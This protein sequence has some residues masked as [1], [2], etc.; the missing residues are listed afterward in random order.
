MNILI[1]G[2]GGFLGRHL[3]R[4]L[5]DRGKV[6]AFSRS[7]DPVTDGLANVNSVAGDVRNKE[8]VNACIESV[9]PDWIIHAA[10]QSYP[11]VSWDDPQGTFEVNV[12]GT[13]NVLEAARQHTPGARI[14][15][16]SSSA[17]YGPVANSTPIAET[18]PL[19]GQSPYGTSK[20]ACDWMSQLYAG[21][22]DMQVMVARPFFIIGPEKQGDAA[23]DFT[24]GLLEIELGRSE[25]LNVGNLA[26]VRDFLPLSDALDA[27]VAILEKGASGE[28]YNICSGEG[29]AVRQL[30]DGLI[31]HIEE[32]VRIEDDPEKCRPLDEPV[33]IGSN[34]KL[35]GLGWSPKK[36]LALA[37]EEMVRLARKERQ[38]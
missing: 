6:T 16:F 13:V 1:T 18:V 5:A 11:G 2:S 37:L 3:V 29:L 25:V 23:S 35:K 10:A 31:Q 30:L 24:S 19:T 17:A 15:V 34:A 8:A 26:A 27:C 33:R 21:R 14:L 36:D 38:A 12:Q 7:I 4:H 9:Q 32:V 20:A 28:A 22:Y